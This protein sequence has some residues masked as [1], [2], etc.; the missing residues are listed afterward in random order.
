M[1]RPGRPPAGAPS[2]WHTAERHGAACAQRDTGWQRED[3]KLVADACGGRAAGG[4][5]ALLACMPEQCPLPGRCD[6]NQGVDGI[7]FTVHPMARRGPSS[8]H[9]TVRKGPKRTVVENGAL[10]RAPSSSRDPRGAASPDSGE[11]PSLARASVEPE[12]FIRSSRKISTGSF[13][14]YGN[15]I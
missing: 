6:C 9:P 14:L 11:L 8:S 1:A 3:A 10:P 13:F 12:E 5:P 4:T 2:P 15:L 7:S